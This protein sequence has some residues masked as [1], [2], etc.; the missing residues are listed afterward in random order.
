MDPGN[1]RWERMYEVHTDEGS[2]QISNICYIYAGYEA[3]SG[4][5]GSVISAPATFH[6][7]PF[8][9][10]PAWASLIRASEGRRCR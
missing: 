10:N 6:G 3:P 9:R 4:R 2:L 5:A 1:N 7:G 8:S